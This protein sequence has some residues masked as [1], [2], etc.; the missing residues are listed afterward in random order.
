MSMRRIGFALLASLLLVL[1]GCRQE[2][3]LERVRQSAGELQAALEKEGLEISMPLAPKKRTALTTRLPSRSVWARSENNELADSIGASNR[4]SSSACC[5]GRSNPAGNGSPG[6][7][8]ATTGAGSCSRRSSR[9]L[10]ANPA[11]P[12][13]R[14]VW[15]TVSLSAWRPDCARTAKAPKLEAD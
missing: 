15:F 14:M 13:T 5:H 9:W 7:R 3:P 6:R 8:H 12:V 11:A 2:G 10:P 1:A 4:T